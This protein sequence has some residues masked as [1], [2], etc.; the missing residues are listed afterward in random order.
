[1]LGTIYRITV[2]KSIL[3]MVTLKELYDIILSLLRW[4]LDNKMK[5]YS[6]FDKE[7]KVCLVRNYSQVTRL[8]VLTP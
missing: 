6:G 1:M 2:L 8:L 7:C 3:T 5:N 4:T